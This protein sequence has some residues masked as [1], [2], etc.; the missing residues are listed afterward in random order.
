M[1][2]VKIN[3]ESAEERRYAEESRV[4]AGLRPAWRIEARP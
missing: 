3:A 2:G 1:R 4:T